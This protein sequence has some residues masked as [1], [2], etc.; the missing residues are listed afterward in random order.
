VFGS[1]RLI[2]LTTTGGGTV[3]LPNP[4]PARNCRIP[5]TPPPPNCLGKVRE[6][7]LRYTGGDCTISNDQDDKASCQGND[8]GP[9]PVGVT[10]TKK[11]DE[12]LADP[13]AGILAGE[14]VSI[15]PSDEDSD[16]RLSSSIKFDV[17]GAGGT[18]R[19]EIH[20][21]CSK[22]LDLRDRFG[23]FEVVGLTTTEGG[24][25]SWGAQVEYTYYVQN[26]SSGPVG[27]VM[28][29]D[30]LL[31]LIDDQISL[32]MGES[33]ERTAMQYI[34]ED[35]TN[36]ATATGGVDGLLCTMDS[37]Q[38][39]VDVLPRRI[40]RKFCGLGAELVFALAPLL[41]LQA[42]RRRRSA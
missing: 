36:V 29:N 7:R 8:P 34:S 12:V 15:R 10:I 2:E 21:S 30:D 35:T 33:V 13:A 24:V 41:W 40:V 5:E 22:P 42:R 19:I 23:S 38:S 28:I 9:G 14:V 1:L 11:P 26:P 16:G 17:S 32:A 6:L 4:V 3:A 25:D 37:A 20:T 18:Q 39:T 31:G 27:D